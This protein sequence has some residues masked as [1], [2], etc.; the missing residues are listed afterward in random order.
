MFFD[1][2]IGYH[3]YF[4]YLFIILEKEHFLLYN[5]KIAVR[6][7]KKNSV[8][9]H[10]IGFHRD[11][12]T[13]RTNAGVMS[14]SAKKRTKEKRRRADDGT[15]DKRQNGQFLELKLVLRKSTD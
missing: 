13:S 1:G 4:L 14:T 15:N 3:Y 7:F 9:E 12:S 11:R 2:W 6:T 10:S 5:S 8:F